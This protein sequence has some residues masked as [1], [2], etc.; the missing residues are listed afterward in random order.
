M[1]SF[2]TI[3]SNDLEEVHM[4]AGDDKTF[5]Y[6][7]RDEN[8]ILVDLTGATCQVLIFTYGDPDNLIGT[9]SG[10]VTSASEAV[11]EFSARLTSACSIALSGMYQQQIKIEDVGGTTHIPSQGKIVIF[12][13]P[14]V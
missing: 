10:T 1:T 9:L 3:V 2:T 14:Q 12:P 5:V 11:G 4:I 13:T 6:T 8:N 7:V